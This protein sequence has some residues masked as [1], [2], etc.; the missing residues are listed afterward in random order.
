VG[1]TCVALL[2]Y[3]EFRSARILTTVDALLAV[4]LTTL[5]YAGAVLW[6]CRL[7]RRTK[8]VLYRQS[9]VAPSV[10]RYLPVASACP[11]NAACHL[12]RMDTAAAA[13][14]LIRI[15][16]GDTYTID[17]SRPRICN[18]NRTLTG[19]QLRTLST[20]HSVAPDLQHIRCHTGP[21]PHRR[22]DD[23]GHSSSRGPSYIPHRMAIA[24]RSRTVRTGRCEYRGPDRSLYRRVACLVVRTSGT[25]H[26]RQILADRTGSRAFLRSSAQS[27]ERHQVDSRDCYLEF[28]TQSSFG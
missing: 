13:R 22:I 17:Q 25:S 23:T 20:G 12:Q 15:S 10:A 28:H 27:P 11:A 7:I 21:A 6:C 16:A 4:R 5:P 3:T 9:L 2:V 24:S 18:L 14:H 26:S 8:T 1:N 19:R